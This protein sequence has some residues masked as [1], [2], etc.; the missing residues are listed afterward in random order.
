MVG[1]LTYLHAPSHVILQS[2][3]LF[4][5]SLQPLPQTHTLV[6]PAAVDPFCGP[7][8]QGRLLKRWRSTQ[9]ASAGLAR[10]ANFSP[11]RS[12]WWAVQGHPGIREH[13]VSAQGLRTL[14]QKFFV[15]SSSLNMTYSCPPLRQEIQCSCCSWHSSSFP[16][17]PF[18]WLIR[19]HPSSLTLQAP[20]GAFPVTPG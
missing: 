19:T 14:L 3:C 18:I 15:S 1:S 17:R 13:S 7:G 5:T 20:S 11:R 12:W 6:R 2:L 4:G 16:T 9:W 10:R 8:S